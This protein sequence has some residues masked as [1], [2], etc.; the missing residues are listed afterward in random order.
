MGEEKVDNKPRCSYANSQTA[1]SHFD[2]IVESQYK[3]R[4]LKLFF[5]KSLGSSASIT[6]NSYSTILHAHSLI[7]HSVSGGFDDDQ[8]V[9]AASFTFII[10]FISEGLL[11]KSFLFLPDNILKCDL[12]NC[13]TVFFVYSVFQL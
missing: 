8:K 1:A 9:K 3:K 12:P 4:R 2:L 6:S 5:F 13:E 11:K 7:V 10:T